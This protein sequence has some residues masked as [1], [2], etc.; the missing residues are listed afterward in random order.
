MPLGSR[1]NEIDWLEHIFVIPQYQGNGIGTCAIRLVE[2]I[3]REYSK[4]L[5]LKLYQQIIG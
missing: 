3:I 5:Y 4:G 2:N 1:G